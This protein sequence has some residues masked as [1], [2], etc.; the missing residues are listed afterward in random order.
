M[1]RMPMVKL[2]LFLV[3]VQEFWSTITSQ[4][5]AATVGDAPRAA[6]P[7]ALHR[8]PSSEPTRSSGGLLVDGREIPA[9]QRWLLRPGAVLNLGGDDFEVHRS[10]HA[11]A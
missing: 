5:R 2:F 1:E 3:S 11:H 7:V 9:F 6:E 8:T 4:I 10:V